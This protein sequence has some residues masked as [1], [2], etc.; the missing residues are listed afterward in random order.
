MNAAGEK[1]ILGVCE[2][3]NQTPRHLAEA[4]SLSLLTDN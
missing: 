3:Q 1:L 2:L 4:L